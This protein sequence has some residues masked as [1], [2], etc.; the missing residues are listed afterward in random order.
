MNNN[1]DEWSRHFDTLLWQ[2]TTILAASIGGL[3]IYCNQ[4]FDLWVS[5]IGLLLT[6]VPV[7][8]A[9]SFR[10]LR[11]R[12]SDQLDPKI[13]EAIHQGRKLFQWEMYCLVFICFEILWVRLLLTKAPEDWPQ[14]ITYIL[15]T[16]AILITIF[17]ASKGLHSNSS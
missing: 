17:L 10:E 15:G 13:Q 1:A 2:V 8:L 12:L 6:I 9:A 5:I 4:Y 14:C 16:F 7:Y 3:F 11:G